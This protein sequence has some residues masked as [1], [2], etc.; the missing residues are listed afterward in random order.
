MTSPYLQHDVAAGS[1]AI[2]D[3]LQRGRQ[4]SSRLAERID[5]KVLV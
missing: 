3:P 4:T 1:A 5:V 2:R